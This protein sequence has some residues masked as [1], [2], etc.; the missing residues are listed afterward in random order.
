MVDGTR[1]ACAEPARRRIAIVQEVVL[2]YRE[3]FYQLLRARLQ[4]T[5]I[6]LVLIHSNDPAADVS[7]SEIDLSW[8]HRVPARRF[9]FGAREMIYQPCRHLVDGCQLVILEQGSRHLLN[10]MLFAEQALGRSQVALWGHGRNLDTDEAS[11]LGEALKAAVNRYAR[12]WF[13]YTD[14]S[15]DIVAEMGFPRRRITTV[16]NANDTLRLR[17]AVASVSAEDRRRT[18]SE[19]GV[20]G[21]HTALYLGNL[22]RHKRLGYLFEASDAV[23]ELLP[24]FELIVAG[25]GTEEKAVRAFASTRSWVHVVGAR[26]GAEK[27]ELLAVADVVLVPAGAGLVVLDSFAAGVPIVTS[28][29]WWHGPERSYVEDGV[30]GLAVDDG[31]D[32]RAYARAVTD[33]LGDTPRRAELRRGCLLAAE[34]YTVEA[35]VERFASG[36]ERALGDAVS[37]NDT[38]RST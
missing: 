25:A 11:R 26:H 37:S 19:I 36:I 9:R 15:A 6:E 17:R 13:A 34:R 28:D 32:G 7:R 1:S 5:G 27:A 2:H 35:M 22:A 18:R 14:A 8:A 21:D 24:D 31:G 29:A 4:Q 38:S 3:R 30:N 12:W 33:L 23:R 20:R 16:Q 10:Y